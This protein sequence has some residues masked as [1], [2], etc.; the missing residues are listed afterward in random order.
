M[1]T[2]IPY[3][4]NSLDTIAKQLYQLK[5]TCQVYTLTGNLGAGKTTL[6]KALLKQFG[7]TEP[8]TSPTFNYVNFY[9]NDKGQAFYHFDLYRIKNIQEFLNNGFDEYLYSPN[10]WAFIEWPTVIEPL[11]THSVCNISI[12]YISDSERQLSYE[13]L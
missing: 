2:I 3:N 11:L 13:V 5:E 1:I 8:I 9:H 7:I 12:E 4:L 10:S 6:L